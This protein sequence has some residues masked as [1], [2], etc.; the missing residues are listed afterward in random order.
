MEGHKSKTGP[1]PGRYGGG[2]GTKTSSHLSGFYPGGTTLSI[3][4]GPRGNENEGKLKGGPA[5]TVR[6]TSGA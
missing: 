3:L 1:V 2:R 5:F 6:D 4:E